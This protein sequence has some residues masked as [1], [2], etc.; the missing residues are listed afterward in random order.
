VVDNQAGGG[1][2]T[3]TKQVRDAP[4]DGLTIGLLNAP[5]MLSYKLFDDENSPDILSD[6]TILGTVVKNQYVLVAGENSGVKELSDL[7]RSD[8]APVFAVTNLK[9][10]Q[11]VAVGVIGN[12]LG[13]DY[14]IIAGIKG[15]GDRVLAAQRADVDVILGS[16]SSLYSYIETGDLVPLL[17]IASEPVTETPLLETTPLLGG[18][19]GVAASRARE[20]GL[21]ESGSIDNAAALENFISAGRIFVAPANLIDDLETC[22]PDLVLSILE[23]EDLARDAAAVNT[24]LDTA[25]GNESRENLES[26]IAGLAR[27]MPAIEKKID[28]IVNAE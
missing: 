2:I 8:I 21:D 1:G 14:K 16:V 24:P 23:S 27:Y 9:S 13:A 3:A 15:T 19:G 11:I 4:P 6:Y 10:S 7:Y 20:L 25:D 18:P 26:A 12:L 17:L 22:L 28:S 5:K